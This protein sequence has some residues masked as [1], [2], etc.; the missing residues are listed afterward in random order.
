MITTANCDILYVKMTRQLQENRRNPGKKIRFHEFYN[1]LLKMLGK[2]AFPDYEADV[3]LEEIFEQH[4]YPNLIAN[5]PYLLQREK[6]HIETTDLFT[7]KAQRNFTQFQ[8]RE[9]TN[10]PPSGKRYT[11]KL[12][13][14]QKYH[15]L[16]FKQN[17]VIPMDDQSEMKN[18]ENDMKSLQSENY[19]ELEQ[20]VLSGK[21]ENAE[22][23]NEKNE[24]FEK[25]GTLDVEVNEKEIIEMENSNKYIEETYINPVEILIPTKSDPEYL[26]TGVENQESAL[27]IYYKNGSIDE[28]LLKDTLSPKPQN[29]RLKSL[30]KLFFNCIKSCFSPIPHLSRTNLLTLEIGEE[31]EYPE[32]ILTERRNSPEWS[33]IASILVS[34]MQSYLTQA[35][36]KLE[37]VHITR[38]EP[39]F[40]NAIGLLG[41]I[42][43]M[44]TIVSIAFSSEVNWLDQSPSDSTFFL[45]SE[46]YWKSAFWS[47][48]VLSFLFFFLVRIGL[49]LLGKGMLGLNPDKSIAKFP[50]WQFFLSKSLSLLG[51]VFYLII[52]RI[53]LS[54]FACEEKNSAW[55]VINAPDLTCFS[56]AHS[57]Y[58]ITA[59]FALLFYY[60]TATL[61]YPNLQY[62]DKALDLKFDT[63]FLV[64]E[65]QS[66]LLIAGFAAFFN[67]DFLWLQLAVVILVAGFLSAWCWLQKP[68][69]IVSVNTWKTGG[70]IGIIWIC[71]W[72]LVNKYAKNM[73]LIAFIMMVAGVICII[74]LLVI[75]QFTVYKAPKK[76]DN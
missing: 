21:Y 75:I 73:K 4:L 61:L 68:C 3:A 26:L 74:I 58:L 45:T 48:F 16:S 56:I 15:K 39:N 10:L 1:D 28:N 52:V 20:S 46:K 49:K 32:N 63:T 42:I 22:I 31:L 5:F 2:M 53:L 12:R 54:A 76:L 40:T 38:L 25:I 36:K 8:K 69:I 14:S 47:A 27:K 18:S 51:D 34:S 37:S 30:V 13:E 23:F 62:Q 7:D 29:K 55:T 33:E 41:Q 60:P 43:E 72:A 65:S 17:K 66:K 9:F 6:S 59:T 44:Y 64:L 24:D 50:S 71:I 19:E 67:S 35:K 57:T 70:Y 11:Q